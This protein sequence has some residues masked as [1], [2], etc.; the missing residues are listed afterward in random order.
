[1]IIEEEPFEFALVVPTTEAVSVTM[2]Y[3]RFETFT[4]VE[5][6]EAITETD[7]YWDKMDANKLLE[8]KADMAVYKL[9]RLRFSQSRQALISRRP[10]R[11]KAHTLK[12]YNKTRRA[13]HAIAQS[14]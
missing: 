6:L 3:E 12:V 13:A 11:L 4:V 9:F 5:S 7:S 8:D 14:K 2:V 10:L 1:M